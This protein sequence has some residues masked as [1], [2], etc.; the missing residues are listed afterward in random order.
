MLQK[1]QDEGSSIELTNVE[2]QAI[3]KGIKSLDAGR[4]VT[5]EQAIEATRKKYGHLFR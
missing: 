1:N 2:K 5:H 3:D 4:I